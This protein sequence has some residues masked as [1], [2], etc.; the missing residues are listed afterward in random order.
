MGLI[1]VQKTHVTCI[2]F[3]SYRIKISILKYY[4]IE[5]PITEHV[6]LSLE[7][8]LLY[9]FTVYIYSIILIPF[10]EL[11]KTR[12]PD[13]SDK[14]SLTRWDHA[15]TLSTLRISNKDPLKPNV[16]ETLSLQ[17]ITKHS[18]MRQDIKGWYG[19]VSL[20]G[21]MHNHNNRIW[22]WDLPSSC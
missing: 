3:R 21:F 16:R 20:R 7:L 5:S 11:N 22:T 19:S 14:S 15:S 12:I 6:I 4:R 8:S 1:L 17:G 10:H 2:S 18:V 13:C 9:R